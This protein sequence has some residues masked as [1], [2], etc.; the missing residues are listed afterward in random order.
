MISMETS[1]VDD[2]VVSKINGLEKIV[3]IHS[4]LVDRLNE[5]V[6]GLYPD[7]ILANVENFRTIEK[8]WDNQNYDYIRREYCR[9][10]IEFYSFVLDEETMFAVDDFLSGKVESLLAFE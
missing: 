1:I 6:V 4:T 9:I 7:E 8:A 2:M 10:W 3:K 5:T